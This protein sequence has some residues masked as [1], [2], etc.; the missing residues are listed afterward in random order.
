MRTSAVIA[1]FIALA[2]GA[3]LDFPVLGALPVVDVPSV[4]SGLPSV[5]E[6]SLAALPSGEPTVLATLPVKREI[7]E[8][9]AAKS[10]DVEVSS[11]PEIELPTLPEVSAL[12]VK[13]LELPELDVP[14]LD[15]PVVGKLPVKRLDLSELDLPELDLPT[16]PEL[17]LPIK[18]DGLGLPALPVAVPEEV[19]NLVNGAKLPI[20]RATPVT[21]LKIESTIEDVIETLKDLLKDI[22]LPE[23]SPVSSITPIATPTPTVAVPELPVKREGLGLPALSGLDLTEVESLELGPT[24]ELVLNILAGLLA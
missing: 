15:L 6:V 10:V 19:T 11:L 21:D 9:E 7:L 13:R 24:I 17:D 1:S 3:P 5:P 14:E 20:K 8:V 16:L 23:V 18:R 22:E 12:P 2:A 4:T